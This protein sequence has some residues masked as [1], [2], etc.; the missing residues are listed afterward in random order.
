MKNIILILTSSSQLL[1]KFPN[2]QPGI[3]LPSAFQ[4]ARDRVQPPRRVNPFTSKTFNTGSEDEDPSVHIKSGEQDTSQDNTY[5]GSF[6]DDFLLSQNDHLFENDPDNFDDGIIVEDEEFQNELSDDGKIARRCLQK[7]PL[8]TMKGKWIAKYYYDSNTNRCKSFKYKTELD[9]PKGGNMFRN[10]HKCQDVCVKPD[11][12]ALEQEPEQ[13]EELIQNRPVLP[14]DH[15]FASK[16][17][18]GMGRFGVGNQRGSGRTSSQ[19]GSA[20]FET[21]DIAKEVDFLGND[22]VQS[23]TGYNDAED[24]SISLK[25]VSKKKELK[26]RTPFTGPQSCLEPKGDPGLCRGFFK[27]FTYDKESNSCVNFIWG[28]CH[29]GM[30]FM[31]SGRVPEE[32]RDFFNNF[33]SKSECE[34]VCVGN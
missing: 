9:V 28:G 5:T 31:L 21:D 6:F 26:N 18:S 27:H 11:P 7:P 2:R 29:G 20:E 33:S 17:F 32:G 15:P 10:R 30:D 19:T 25:T 1:A 34:A 16:S 22:E 23:S 14:D 3:R 4:N 8:S 13:S 24:H 12:E